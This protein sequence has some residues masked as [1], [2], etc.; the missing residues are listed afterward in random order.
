[1]VYFSNSFSLEDRWQS[2]DRCHR[3]G[4]TKSVTYI[5][6]LSDLP[7][8]GLVQKALASKGSMAIY[9]SDNLADVDD[10]V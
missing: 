2:E 10:A 5:D 6:L 1:V 3:T 4:Q 9:V 8:D 7:I